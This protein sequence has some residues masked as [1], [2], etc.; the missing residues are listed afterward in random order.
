MRSRLVLAALMRRDVVQRA[1]E[2]FDAVLVEGEDDMTAEQVIDAAAD[3]ADAIMFTSTLPLSAH[4]I[5]RLPQCAR[6]SHAQCS[7]GGDAT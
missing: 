4:A 1:R 3:R 6:W 7:A 5:S 2:D